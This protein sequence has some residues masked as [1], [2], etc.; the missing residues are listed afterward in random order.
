[1]IKLGFEPKS[2]HCKSNTVLFCTT[3]FLC[4]CVCVTLTSLCHCLQHCFNHFSVKK[5]LYTQW[6]SARNWGPHSL[7]GG[8]QDRVYL[9]SPWVVQVLSAIRKRRIDADIIQ[10]GFQ[11]NRDLHWAWWGGIIQIERELE[12]RVWLVFGCFSLRDTEKV[13]RFGTFIRLRKPTSFGVMLF[14][15]YW[16]FKVRFVHSMPTKNHSVGLGCSLA[17]C[18]L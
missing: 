15:L 4:V 16:A 11:K 9:C 5:L 1:M 14:Q 10:E 12:R 7:I 13:M 8:K 17:I 3:F 6:A 2:S 18:I